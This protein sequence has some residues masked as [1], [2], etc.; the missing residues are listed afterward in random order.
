MNVRRRDLT[1]KK[2]LTATVLAALVSPA[3]AGAPAAPEMDAAAGVAAI[4][5]V[6]G[7]LAI[8]REKTK[9]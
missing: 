7:V 4:A 5:L 2:L 3:Y 1:V 6:T 8:I 9:K